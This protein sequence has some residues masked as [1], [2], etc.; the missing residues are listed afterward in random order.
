MHK[1][2]VTFNL[3]SG[4][5]FIGA[6]I[7]QLLGRP[8]SEIKI[9]SKGDVHQ[10]CN[11]G[12]YLN[13]NLIDLDPESVAWQEF[14]QEFINKPSRDLFLMHCMNLQLISRWSRKIVFISFD[15]D[16]CTTMCRRFILKMDDVVEQRNMYTNIAGAS[17]PTYNEFISMPV[18]PTWVVDEI[19]R[20]EHAKISAWKWIMPADTSCLFEI[21]FKQVT[22][23]E[24]LD[25]LADFVGATNWDRDKLQLK[26]AEYHYANKH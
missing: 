18:K 17:W 21:P 10:F 15:E 1:I 3:G 9:S 26:I 14:E 19:Q 24:W 8:G 7:S 25:N 22:T 2:T 13:K 11:F 20:F 4:G 16:D 12:H 23:G 6:V 5:H